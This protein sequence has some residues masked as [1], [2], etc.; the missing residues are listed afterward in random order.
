MAKHGAH[1]VDSITVMPE[2]VDAAFVAR[3]ADWR[4]AY[5]DAD[6]AARVAY[7]DLAVELVEMLASKKRHEGYAMTL[8]DKYIHFRRLACIL[9]EARDSY[10]GTI[11]TNTLPTPWKPAPTGTD[12]KDKPDMSGYG[13]GANEA[14]DIVYGEKP[15]RNKRD[16][17]ESDDETVQ[18]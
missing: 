15:Y 17:A 12:G 11:A 13:T 8:A 5:Y 10:A 2:D 7:R 14:H 9:V 16:S 6:G 4:G 18:Y 3:A 1:G